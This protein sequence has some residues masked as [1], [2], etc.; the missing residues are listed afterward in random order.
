METKIEVQTKMADKYQEANYQFMLE[1]VKLYSE[2]QNK[3]KAKYYSEKLKF[4]ITT[5]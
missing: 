5:E 1:F 4:D 3:A 2:D